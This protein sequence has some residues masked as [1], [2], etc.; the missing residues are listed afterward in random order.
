MTLQSGTF[1]LEWNIKNVY[2]KMSGSKLNRN[3]NSISRRNRESSADHIR[4]LQRAITH[5]NLTDQRSAHRRRTSR[6]YLTTRDA[7]QSWGHSPR[8]IR[9]EETES[10]LLKCQSR[11]MFFRNVCPSELWLTC[12]AEISDELQY[13]IQHFC[14]EGSLQWILYPRNTE[15]FKYINDGHKRVDDTRILTSSG[16]MSTLVLLLS[17]DWN[18]TDVVQVFAYFKTAWCQW[19]RM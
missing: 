3:L 17:Y 7:R 8:V 1:F 14:I 10:F 4:N 5:Q 2:W 12:D 11:V 16:S 15:D 6:G 9:I 19:N 18:D 13:Q